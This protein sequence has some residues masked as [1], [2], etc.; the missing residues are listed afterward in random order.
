ME[1]SWIVF[2][3]LTH[4]KICQEQFDKMNVRSCTE[5]S[6]YIL[7]RSGTEEEFDD[8]AQLCTDLDGKLTHYEKLAQ[9]EVDEK[10]RI[11]LEKSLKGAE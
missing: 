5:L 6:C 1:N 9:K 10:Q 4:I 11:K 8:Y 7:N 3:L 2:C